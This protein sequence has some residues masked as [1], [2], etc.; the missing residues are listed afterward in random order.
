MKQSSRSG[1]T[2][3]EVLVT[4]II[5]GVAIGSISSLFISARNVRAN[6]AL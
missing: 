6:T 1:F 4:I 2:V 5:M 3:V